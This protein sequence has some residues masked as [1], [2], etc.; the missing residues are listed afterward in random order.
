MLLTSLA[1]ALVGC[2]AQEVSSRPTLQQIV[3]DL[4]GKLPVGAGVA[5]KYAPGMQLWTT[6]PENYSVDGF[7]TGDHYRINK[8][9]FRQAVGGAR[10]VAPFVLI[11]V[12]GTPCFEMTR[13]SSAFQAVRNPHP[14]TTVVHG[15]R[16]GRFSADL[17]GREMAEKQVPGGVLR[18]IEGEPGKGCLGH[19][20]A[21]VRGFR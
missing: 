17:I 2:A 9:E 18:F 5:G 1:A 6:H 20:A 21:D 13:V 15:V 11:E 4:F 14:S 12:S 3:G 16:N 7:R 19:I 10:N 8:I